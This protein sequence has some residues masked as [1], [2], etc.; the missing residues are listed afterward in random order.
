MNIISFDNAKH[1]FFEL[2]NYYPIKFTLT[3]KNN[4]TKKDE[5]LTFNSIEQYY[6]SEKYNSSNTISQ[7]YRSFILQ[8]NTPKK[9]HMIGKQKK[10]IYDW[11]V[12]DDEKITVKKVIDKYKGIVKI[13]SDWKS[14]KDKVLMKGLKEKFKDKYLKDLLLST[15]NKVLV[16][17]SIGIWGMKNNKLGEALMKLRDLIKSRDLMKARNVMKS[18][19]QIKKKEK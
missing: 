1:K 3:I 12:N 13:R 10:F 5:V 19:N 11:P 16:E 9:A 7:I 2:S 8:A 17:N 18:R 6:Q 4:K 15:N 14:V